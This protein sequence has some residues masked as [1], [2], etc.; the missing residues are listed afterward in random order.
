MFEGG[1]MSKNPKFKS[2]QEL[3]EKI[4]AYFESCWAEVIIKNQYGPVMVPNKETGEKEPLMERI[5]IRPY[6]ITGLAV[7]L[8]T[9]RETLLDYEAKDGYSD[10]IKK[11]KAKIEQFTEEQ[12]FQ[13]R[14]PAGAIF[15][16]VNNYKRWVNKQ[17]TKQEITGKDGEAI[18]F[19][20]IV[21]KVK[22]N[23]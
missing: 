3:Q 22:H 14:N 19:K 1:N 15:N 9:T 10:T 11:A 12:L 18:P 16:L 17:E 13:L 20:I 7:A 5:Q 6:T 4:D 21:E 23:E 8:D 2:V